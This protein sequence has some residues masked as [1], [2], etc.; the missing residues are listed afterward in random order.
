MPISGVLAPADKNAYVRISMTW[1]LMYAFASF[2]HLHEWRTTSMSHTFFFSQLLFRPL[3]RKTWNTIT[4]FGLIFPTFAILGCFPY[5]LCYLNNTSLFFITLTLPWSGAPLYFAWS[6]S[7]YSKTGSLLSGGRSG[8]SSQLGKPNSGVY[9][10]QQASWSP[11][12][13]DWA[14]IA[15]SG[16][17]SSQGIGL[18]VTHCKRM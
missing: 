9:S 3:L 17:I 14:A 1:A 11:G 12:I 16:S 4:I 6:G 7:S 8:H 13:M 2:S 10:S 18:V 15:V 5:S